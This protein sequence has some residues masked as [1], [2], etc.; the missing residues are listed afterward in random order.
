M[1]SG[2]ILAGGQRLTL[3]DV[4]AQLNLDAARLVVLS[5]C[6]TGLIDVRQSPDEFFGLSSG[7]LQ[8]GAP[9]V[10]ST[11]WRVNDLSTMLLMERFYSGHL[12]ENLTPAAA[13]RAAQR[14]LRD[15]TVQELNLGERWAQIYRTAADPRLKKVSFN[16]MRYYPA[17]LQ[18]RPFAHPYHWAAF[19]LSGA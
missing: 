9:T 2:L 1:Q 10:I 11:L 18:G 12:K 7:F 17:H 5:A 19:T 15:A 3:A 13:L 4:V 14:W 6:E 16:A 8:A